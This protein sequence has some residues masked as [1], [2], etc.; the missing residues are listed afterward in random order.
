[1]SALKSTLLS[2][3]VVAA[4]IGPASVAHADGCYNCGAGSTNGCQQC[5]YSGSD[6]FAARK[7]CQ[8][9]GCKITG[10]SSCSTAANIKVCR[11][12]GRSNRAPAAAWAILES[13]RPVSRL[14]R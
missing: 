3:G 11:S 10:T 2:L 12:D 5:R 9:K 14:N 8:Q 6:T 7:V 13:L 4:V 1:M